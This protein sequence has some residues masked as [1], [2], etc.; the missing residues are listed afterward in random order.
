MFTGIVTD[1]G[2]VLGVEERAEGLRRLTIACAY[3]RASIAI[4]AS[5]ACSRRVHDGGRDRQQRQ[6][7][8]FSVDAAAETLRLTTV[9]RW[10]DGHARQSGALAQDGRR[11]RR[12]SG[13]RPRR[14][15]RRARRARGPDRHG[16]LDAAR[17]EAA[18]ALHRAERLG[19]ARRRVADGERRDR[20]HVLGAD[21]PAHTRRHDIRRAES[22]RQHQPRSRRDGALRGAADG[23]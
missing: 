17:A 6:R 18:R 4:G 10:R 1:V 13:Q 9:G 5:I 8:T 15:S 19:R 16:A 7:D 22:R 2:E 21:H 11:A 20:R 23:G 12:P 3:D 14:R